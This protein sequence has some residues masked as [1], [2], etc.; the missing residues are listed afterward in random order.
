ML[1]K[2]SHWK[3]EH[4]NK[5]ASPQFEMNASFLKNYSL[6]NIQNA[7]DIGCGGGNTTAWM[8]DQMQNGFITGI[9]ASN[10]MIEAAIQTHKKSNLKFEYCSVEELDEHNHYDLVT[11]FFCMQWVPNK[12]DAFKKIA[13]ALMPEG[14]FLMIAP[15]PHPHLPH[16]RQK[17]MAQKEWVA[18][19]ENYE[20]PLR[21]ITDF[22]YEEYAKTASLQIGACDTQKKSI[23]FENKNLFSNFMYEMTPNL[24]TLPNEE[25]KQRFLQQ[26]LDRYFDFY[27]TDNQG[28]CQIDFNLIRLEAGKCNT[29]ATGF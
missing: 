28:R 10:S 18:F 15:S 17:L 26:L 16:I 8:A 27:P 22:Q 1:K 25:L 5:V 19:F 14:R 2:T 4:Y 20:D 6:M 29:S 7:L 13:K 24:Q 12:R 3:G 11:S 21:H 9:D 23:F